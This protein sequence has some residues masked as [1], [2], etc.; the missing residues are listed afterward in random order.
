MLLY[1]YFRSGS[2]VGRRRD[3]AVAGSK[4]SIKSEH[5]DFSYKDVSDPFTERK[6]SQD[7]PFHFDDC[8]D[9]DFGL[10]KLD[11]HNLPKRP[12]NAL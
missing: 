9:S 4:Q 3:P 10:G 7:N 8:V 1:N 12:R 11:N 5:R 6:P 2:D